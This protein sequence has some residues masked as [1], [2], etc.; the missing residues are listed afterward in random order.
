MK[1]N[2]KKTYTE[3]AHFQNYLQRRYM[4]MQIE[5]NLIKNLDKEK[6]YIEKENS[7]KKKI[8]RE[9]ANTEKFYT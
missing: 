2:R 6:T 3:T 4:R 5:Y 8:C 9:R 7:W 1:I